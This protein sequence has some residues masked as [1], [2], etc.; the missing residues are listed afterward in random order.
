MT[1]SNHHVSLIILPMAV[2]VVMANT[3]CQQIENGSYFEQNVKKSTLSLSVF[4]F[5][6]AAMK[7]LEEKGIIH[8]H[9]HPGNVLFHADK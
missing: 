7:Y 2:R 9:I 4:W 6:G 5:A 1:S 3:N 8:G